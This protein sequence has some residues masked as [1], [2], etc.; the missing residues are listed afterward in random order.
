[1]NKESITLGV[2]GL[3]IGLLLGLLIGGKMLGGSGATTPTPAQTAA[4]MVSQADLNARIAEIENVVAKDPKNVQAWVT[5]GNDY[6]DAHNPQKA[7]QAYAKALELNPNDP[8]VLT[9]QGVMF[10]ALGFFDKALANFEKASKLNPQHLQSLYNSG[11]V[12]AVDMKQPAKARPIFERVAQQGGSSE[13]G[14]QAREMLQQLP[15]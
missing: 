3:I 4:P 6:F 1:M 5:L 9:D 11:I 10:R 15:K 14:N 2:A 12:Y 7:V 8:N 13:L